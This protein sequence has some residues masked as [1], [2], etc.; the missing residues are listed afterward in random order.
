MPELRRKPRK[1]LKEL[2]E[3]QQKFIN[4]LTNPCSGHFANLTTSL[5]DAGY[6][7][8]RNPKALAVRLLANQNILE[9]MLTHVNKLA[10]STIIRAET[11]KEK[12][13]IEL[14]SAL[15][16]CKSTGDMTNRIRVIE[17][18]GKFHQLWSDKVT[19]SVESY[20]KMSAEHLAELRELSQLRLLGNGS[21]MPATF[22]IP[23]SAT[24][25]DNI[26]PDLQPGIGTDLLH[27]CFWP[28]SCETHT[29]DTGGAD[30]TAQTIIT[31]LVDNDT[32]V[33]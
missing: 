22:D 25:D 8:G 33:Q 20:E 7:H 13:W 32:Q 3:K 27:D 29:Q 11:A 4:N 2:T 9:G 18:M 15:N 17:L 30:N 1:D 24:I 26:S 12:I 5:Q 6:K 21:I 31:E 16:D 28:V 10:A 19:I 14:E 23:A